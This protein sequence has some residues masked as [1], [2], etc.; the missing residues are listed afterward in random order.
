META[1]K[2]LIS[3]VVSEFSVFG[4]EKD[5]SC[6]ADFNVYNAKLKQFRAERGISRPYPVAVAGKPVSFEF[7][8]D[9]IP[10]FEFEWDSTVCPPDTDEA[11]TE[12]FIPDVWFPYGWHVES[13]DG[14]GDIREEP[15]NHRLFIKTKEVCRCRI[16][17][18][19]GKK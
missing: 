6:T 9:G 13:F 10:F 7:H 15:V 4:P 3:T 16:K 11:D 18:S 17:I 14:S 2:E 5:T 12:I 1:E 19:A 8:T